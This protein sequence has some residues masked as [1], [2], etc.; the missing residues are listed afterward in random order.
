MSSQSN[1]TQAAASPEN[2][3]WASVFGLLL[4]SSVVV[5]CGLGPMGNILPLASNIKPVCLPNI[6]ESSFIP[7]S[8]NV[9]V[10]HHAG[11]V[12]EYL[13]LLDGIFPVEATTPSEQKEG[14]NWGGVHIRLNHTGYIQQPIFSYGMRRIVR[15]A[16]VKASKSKN[17]ERF[18][19]HQ[20]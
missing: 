4:L 12:H 8:K 3:L 19:W 11:E 16:T 15:I 6:S 5:G 20:S 10:G 7:V 17:I 9:V 14:I 1:K 2:G 18:L 13:G